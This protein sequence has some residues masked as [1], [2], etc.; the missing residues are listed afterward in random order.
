M[1]EGFRGKGHAYPTCSL[2]LHLAF[3]ERKSPASVGHSEGTVDEKGE[4]EEVT[5]N[6]IKHTHT[7]TQGVNGQLEI[8]SMK[9]F[10]SH[11]HLSR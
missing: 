2:G 9:S 8:V 10:A 1:A 6:A 5:L 3:P 4:M 7:H 11:L